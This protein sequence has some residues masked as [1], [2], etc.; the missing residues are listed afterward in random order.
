MNVPLARNS[1]FIL[2]DHD[3]LS[4]ISLSFGCE[5]DIEI[6]AGGIF[7]EISC[8]DFKITRI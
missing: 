2:F 4:H 5:D 1:N 7:L 3:E 8:D 6:H